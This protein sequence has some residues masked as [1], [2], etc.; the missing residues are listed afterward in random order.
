M[1]TNADSVPAQGESTPHAETTK[2]TWTATSET[3][4]SAG[5]GLVERVHAYCRVAIAIIATMPAINR[6]Q[7]FGIR[8]R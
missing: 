6:I 3:C 5:M 1:W 8:G 7:R 2:G 4:R